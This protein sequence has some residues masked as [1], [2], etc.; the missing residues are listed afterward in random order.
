MGKKNNGK[1]AAKNEA[2]D[3][4]T[5]VEVDAELHA[6]MSMEMDDVF[7]KETHPLLYRHLMPKFRDGKLKC[8]AGRVSI[9]I[10]GKVYRVSLTMP[11]YKTSVVVLVE[12]LGSWMDE[13]ERY[14]ALP[15]RV[16]MPMWE[17]NKKALP[18]IDD[19]IK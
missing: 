18:T 17:K 11:T 5:K 12:S 3:A 7:L 16:Y 14:L 9:S 1:P 4:D 6:A 10:E 8:A 2:D 19:L 13:M 15:T